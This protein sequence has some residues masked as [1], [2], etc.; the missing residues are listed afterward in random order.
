MILRL[1]GTGVG[2]LS[3]DRTSS[4]LSA[5]FSDGSL[6]LFDAGEGCSRAMMRDGLDLNNIASVHISHTHPD[7]WSGLTGLLTAWL[8]DGREKGVTV[9]GPAPSL[10]FFREVQK[11]SLFFDERMS[12]QINYLPLVECEL[13]DGWSLRLFTTSHLDKVAELAR[14][15]G[16]CDQARGFVLRNGGKTIVLSQDLGAESDLDGL[17]EGTTLLV[18]ESTHVDPADVLR[19]AGEAGVERVVFTHVP[20]DGGSFPEGDQGILW[21]VAS[22]GERIDVG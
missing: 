22:E 6:V 19:R 3:P 17:L 1:H 16:T 12:F 8:I 13:R 14:A 7:H 11:H 15:S 18:C 10:R 9:H 2:L 21:S 4:A 5:E 20:P